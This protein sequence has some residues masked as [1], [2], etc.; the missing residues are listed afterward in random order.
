M[1]QWKEVQEKGKVLLQSNFFNDMSNLNKGISDVIKS[2][3]MIDDILNIYQ[4]NRFVIINKT[5]DN[6]KD[7]FIR[8]IKNVNNI[9][10]KFE[11]K[12]IIS[13]NTFLNS[14]LIGYLISFNEMN[15][16][17]LIN[18]KFHLLTLQNRQRYIKSF[19]KT[20]NNIETKYNKTYVINKKRSKLNDLE[21][22]KQYK[23]PFKEIQNVLRICND[24]DRILLHDGTYN[25]NSEIV[26]K[27]NICIIGVGRRN[28]IHIN[29]MEF[30]CG[31]LDKRCNIKFENLTINTYDTALIIINGTTLKVKNCIF[32]R[33]IKLYSESKFE[34]KNCIFQKCKQAIQLSM[35]TIHV[36][37][38]KCH[39][40]NINKNQNQK[41]NSKLIHGCVI[42]KNHWK[43]P[44]HSNL[45][46]LYLECIENH[47]ENIE[48][49][50]PF[51]EVSGID[52][53]EQCAVYEHNN[54][55]IIRNTTNDENHKHVNKLHTC[56]KF[57][58]II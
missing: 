54:Y 53:N 42:I 1:I 16:T 32:E 45:P 23:G 7:I 43:D 17:I 52:Q 40:L 38:I 50:Y 11:Y 26:I 6:I 21:K 49:N 2:M 33:L 28:K 41:G 51:I 13:I 19:Y 44:Q 22:K 5:N 48:D 14:D 4:R 36:K 29:A 18:K 27:K 10:Q 25:L 12:N 39:F 55:T 34:A 57:Y 3:I 9:K 47:F 8:Y 37:L 15:D 30:F 31:T 20:I 56:Y 58:D 46:T 35:T 24:N